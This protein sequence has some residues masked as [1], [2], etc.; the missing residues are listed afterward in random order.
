MSC[1]SSSFV[2]VMCVFNMQMSAWVPAKHMHIQRLEEDFYCLLSF[3]ASCFETGSFIE[4]E[5]C[6]FGK[7]DFTASF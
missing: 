5:A 2:F 3:S 1:F 4:L 7:S 6:Y